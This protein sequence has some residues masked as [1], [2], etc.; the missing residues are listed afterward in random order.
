M[1]KRNKWT[2]GLAS[3][4]L[5]LTLL[6]GFSTL[7]KGFTDFSFGSIEEQAGLNATA[8]ENIR[9]LSE[10]DT[11]RQDGTMQKE[12]LFTIEPE[13]ARDET[14]SYHLDWNA[15]SSAGKESENWKDG[16]KAED[17]VTYEVKEENSRIVFTCGE[18]FGHQMKFVM[19]SVSNPDIRASLTLDY[20]RKLLSN[21][22]IKTTP[23]FAPGKAIQVKVID[24]VYSIGT[25]GEKTKDLKPTIDVTYKDNGTSYDSLFADIIVDGINSQNYKYLGSDYNSPD[26]LLADMKEKVRNYLLKIPSESGEMTFDQATFQSYLTYSYH[27]YTTYKP[28]YQESRVSLNEFIKRYQNAYASGSGFHLHVD[29]EGKATYDNLIALGL[30]ASTLTDISF[31]DSS[32]V[33]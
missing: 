3:F 19:T 27:A 14:F 13:S 18:A 2:I 22:R 21:A 24:E 10:T 23:T 26:K 7:T 33:F 29:A 31:S 20:K 6:G 25:K 28:I 32:I 15:D 11:M 30:S 4:C 16:K 17:Y 12:I 9:F 8:V 1:T 5:S